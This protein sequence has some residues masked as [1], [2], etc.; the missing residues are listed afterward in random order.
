MPESCSLQVSGQELQDMRVEAVVLRPLITRRILPATTS[1]HSL[2]ALVALLV[3]DASRRQ[4]V[5]CLT[6]NFTTEEHWSTEPQVVLRSATSQDLSLNER[7]AILLVLSS[8]ARKL[9]SKEAGA[10]AGCYWMLLPLV[11]GLR[12][13]SSKRAR[14]RRPGQQAEATAAV[15][16]CHALLQLHPFSCESRILATSTAFR[17]IAS[18]CISHADACL[19]PQQ[20]TPAVSGVPRLRCGKMSARQVLRRSTPFLTSAGEQAHFLERRTWLACVRF[21]DDCQ[22]GSSPMVEQPSGL[23]ARSLIAQHS[24]IM[25]RAEASKLCR[26]RRDSPTHVEGEPNL[27]AEFLRSLAV[28]FL[29]P[30]APAHPSRVAVG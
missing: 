5:Q 17:E 27:V 19:F 30:P 9:S 22:G 11:P 21:V 20:E 1:T 12:P 16:P 8:A 4:A 3:A 13:K 10:W 15:P 7:R 23:W 2:Q 14:S 26:W 18:V 24:V 28:C 29:D 6:A 25:Y